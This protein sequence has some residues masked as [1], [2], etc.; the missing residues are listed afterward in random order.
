MEKK[1]IQINFSQ[2][3]H[4]SE[5]TEIQQLLVSKA[6]TILNTAYAVYS[7][8]HVGA[9]LLLESGEII[10]GNNQENIAFPSSLCA[11]RVAL[12]FAKAHHPDAVVKKIAIMA[13]S[14]KGELLEV[15]SPCGSCRQVMSEY[16]RIQNE[17]MEV[18]IKGEK[19]TMIV[20][21]KVEDLLP[22]SF[23]TKVLG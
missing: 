3:N 8:F 10:T 14:S 13:K 6:E 16:E 4:K 11:E 7:G 18:I 5:L 1:A 9:A 22:F 21:E 12:Y 19:D 15:I 2:Y 17:P 20:F 23:S